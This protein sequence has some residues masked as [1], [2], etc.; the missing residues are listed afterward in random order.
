MS[1]GLSGTL[2]SYQRLPPRK[3]GIRT[4][5][6][7]GIELADV[8][9][10]DSE[11]SGADHLRHSE[12]FFDHTDMTDRQLEEQ[13][14]RDIDCAIERDRAIERASHCARAHGLWCSGLYRVALPCHPIVSA[15]LLVLTNRSATLPPRSLLSSHPFLSLL[16]HAP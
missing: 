14:R 5:R 10:D 1:H 16:P 12:D 8:R 7:G 11:G 3:M 15:L 2:Q 6:H 9:D 4:Q 13:V